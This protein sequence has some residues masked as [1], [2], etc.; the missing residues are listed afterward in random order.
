MFSKCVLFCN[1]IFAPKI[2]IIPNKNDTFPCQ[3]PSTLALAASAV[4]ADPVSANIVGY[5]KV[6]VGAISLIGPMFTDVNAGVA[7]LQLGSI[8][9]NENY[10]DD[11]SDVIQFLN[12]DGSLDFAAVY[13]G[14]DWGWFSGETGWVN[15]HDID[16]GTGFMV[17]TESQDVEYLIA[18][19][20]NTAPIEV[21]VAQGVAVIGN[22]LPVIITLDQLIPDENYNDDG[23]DV[24]QFLNPDGSLDFAAVYYGEDW[25]WF[26]GEKDWVNEEELKP[27]KCVFATIE[28]AGGV[29]FS[30]PELVIAE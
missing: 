22:G 27:G 11:G 23:S 15:D 19:E 6:S 20:V 12:P 28:T 3:N 18:G 2:I 8:M 26:S 24:I 7:S 14:A 9:P 17:F 5:T 1:T 10:N 29:V 30:L 4:A 13:Y 16:L 21:A 25:G